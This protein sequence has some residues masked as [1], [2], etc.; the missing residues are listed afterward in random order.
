MTQAPS[1]SSESLSDASVE[2]QCALPVCYYY[3]LE[4]YSSLTYIM[5]NNSNLSKFRRG[6]VIGPGGVI[7]GPGRRGQTLKT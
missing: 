7:L 2:C 1:S 3:A 6:G 5:G 4:N